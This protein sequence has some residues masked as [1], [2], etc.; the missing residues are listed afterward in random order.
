M[1]DRAQHIL[2]DWAEPVAYG[3]VGLAILFLLEGMGL[4]NGPVGWIVFGVAA[5]ILW[6]LVRSAYLEQ[7]LRSAG[8]E[9]PGLVDVDERRIAYFGPAG[10]GGVSIDALTR[11]E[12]RTADT[13]PFEEDVHWAFHVEGQPGPALMI[14]NGAVGAERLLTALSALPGF[15]NDAV[16][17]AMGSTADAVFLIWRKPGSQGAIAS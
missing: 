2:R 12:I 4:M 8:T 17:R 3:A 5:F 1:W 9:G 13:G 16:I 6:R 10:G 14:P 7:V 11:V 15:D